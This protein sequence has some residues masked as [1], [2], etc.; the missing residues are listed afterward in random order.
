MTLCKLLF[1]MI[2]NQKCPKIYYGYLIGR[3][4]TKYV[5]RLMG[6]S[7]REKAIYEFT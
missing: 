7:Y 3:I 4:S 6:Y 1:I 2:E 5:S